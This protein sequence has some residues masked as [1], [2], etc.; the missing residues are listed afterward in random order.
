MGSELSAV[1]LSILNGECMNSSLNSTFTT[2]IPKKVSAN[3]INDYC[4]IS[5]YNVLYKLVSKTMN[6]RLKSVM[7]S[8]ISSNQ[9]AFIS[10]RLIIDNIIVA[11]ELLHSLKKNKKGKVGKMVVK[12][13]MSKTYDRVE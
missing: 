3:S 11:Y 6:D 4:P 13:D 1:V 5:L 2:L 12:L 9:S 10:G 7:H 8:I